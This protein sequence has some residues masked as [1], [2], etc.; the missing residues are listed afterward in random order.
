M[1]DLN[2]WAAPPAEAD[3]WVLPA[4][5]PAPTRARIGNPALAA[6]RAMQPQLG[7]LPG[8]HVA[9]PAPAPLDFERN[10]SRIERPAEVE[11]PPAPRQMT[12]GEQAY[13]EMGTLDRMGDQV[14]SGVETLRQ[15]FLTMPMMQAISRLRELDEVDAAPDF[16]T[17]AP[18]SQRLAGPEMAEERARQRAAAEARLGEVLGGILASQGRQE[19]LAANPRAR[20]LVEAGNAGRWGEVWSLLRDDPAGIIQQFSVESAPNAALSIIPGLAGAALGGRGLAFAAGGVGGYA[21]DVGPRMIEGLTQFMQSTGVDTRDPAAVRTWIGANPQLVALAAQE[22][23]RGALGPAIADALTMGLA[24]GIRPGAGVVRNTGRVTANVGMETGFEMGG[25]ALA[26]VLARGEVDKPGEILAEGLGALPQTVGSTAVGT[27][28]ELRDRTPAAPT[29]SP[30]AA[31]PGGAGTPPL[32]PSAAPQPGSSPQPGAPEGAAAPNPIPGAPVAATPISGAADAAGT[33][34][35]APPAAMPSAGAAPPGVQAPPPAQPALA[36]V[37]AAPPP[38]PPPPVNTAAASLEAALNQRDPAVVAAERAATVQRWQAALPQGFEVVEEDGVFSVLDPTGDWIAQSD[39]PTD[40]T[41]AES[42]ADIQ[43]R[44]RQGLYPEV[45]ATQQ[46]FGEPEQVA[47]AQQLAQQ[48]RERQAAERAAAEEAERAQKEQERQA[49]E[50]ERGRRQELAGLAREMRAI[51]AEFAQIGDAE[52]AK[53]IRGSIQPRLAAGDLTRDAVDRMRAYLTQ[54]KARRDAEKAAAAPGVLDSATIAGIQSGVASLDPEMREL[55]AEQMARKL[56]KKGSLDWR[57]VPQELNAAMDTVA[58]GA[59]RAGLQANPQ[60]VIALVRGG[61]NSPAT[62]QPPAPNVTTPAPAPT[63]A[64]G[65]GVGNVTTPPADVTDGEADEVANRPARTIE[66]ARRALEVAGSVLLPDGRRVGVVQTPRAGWIIRTRQADGRVRELG[67]DPRG[68][69]FSRDEAIARALRDERFPDAT[70]A[71]AATTP[72]AAP[73]TPIIEQ[74]PEPSAPASPPTGEGAP[75]QAPATAAAPQGPASA[76]PPDDLDDVFDEIADEEDAKAAVAAAPPAT[77]DPDAADDAGREAAKHAADITGHEAAHIG[78]GFALTQSVNI[79]GKLILTPVLPNGSYLRRDI[80]SVDAPPAGMAQDVFD[81]AKAAASRIRAENDAIAERMPDGPFQGDETVVGIGALGELAANYVRDFARLVGL[82]ERRFL[83]VDGSLT[84]AQARERGV[85]GNFIRGA[86]PIP[87][88]SRDLAEVGE[89]VDGKATIIRL[90]ARVRRAQ[91]PETMAHEIGHVLEKLALREAPDETKAAIRAAFE[92]FAGRTATLPFGEFAAALRA[93]VTARS[94]QR[95]AGRDGTLEIPVK[96]IGNAAYWQ[97]FSEWFA[98]QVARWAVTDEKPLTIVDRFFAR[99][100]RLYRRLVARVGGISGQPAPAVRD[101]LNARQHPPVVPTGD[102]PAAPAPSETTGKSDQPPP[103]PAAPSA[104]APTGGVKAAAAALQAIMLGQKGR[105]MSEGGTAPAADPA[106]FDADTYALVMPQLR[107]AVQEFREA[108]G[109]V[110]QL[111]RLTYT[112]LTAEVAAENRAQFREWVKPYITQFARDVTSGKVRLEEEPNDA[113]PAIQPDGAE[114]LD[115]VAPEGGGGNAEGGNTRPGGAGGQQGSRPPGGRSGGGRRPGPRSGGNR[116]PAGD[117]PAAGAGPDV[118]PEATPSEKIEASSPINVPALDF[119]IDSSLELGRGTELAKFADNMEAIRT[120]KKIEREGRRASPDE[121]RVLARYVGWGGLKNAFRVAGARE[122]EGVTKGWEKRVA[123]VEDLL[124]PAELKAARNSTTAAHY[125]SQTVVQAMWRAVERLGFKGGSVLEPSVGTGNFLGLMPEGLRGTSRVFAVEYDSLTA[126]MAQNLYPNQTVIHSGFQSVPLPSGQFALAIGNPPFGRESLFFRSRPEVNG[127]SIHNQFFLASIDAVAPGGL[128]SMVVSHNLMDALDN[129]TR[130]ALAAK[131]DFLGGI[132]LPDM[133]FRENARTEVVTDILFFRRRLWA[134]EQMAIGVVEDLQARKMP[135][136]P[137]RDYL[138]MRE[139]IQ[140]WTTSNEIPDPAGSGENIN[141]NRYFERR[142]QMVVG[143]INA[144]GTMNARRELNVTLADPSQFEPRLNAAIERLPLGRRMDDLAQTSLQQFETMADAMRLAVEGA[145]DGRITRSPDGTLKMVLSMDGGSLGRNVL[146]EITL[147]ADTP[148]NDEYTYTADGKWQRTVDV[149]G[150]DGKKAKV[151]DAE[152]RPTKRNEKQTLTFEREADIPARDRYGATRIAMVRDMLAVKDLLK[153]QLMLET[154]DAP[155]ARIEENRGRLN[156]AYDAFVAKHGQMHSPDV[157]RIA[158]RM[159]DGGLIMATEQVGGS[160]KAPTYKKAAIMSRRVTA[161][162]KPVERAKDAEDAVAIV[163]GESGFIDIDRVAQLLNTDEAGAERALAAGDNPRAFFDPELKRWEARDLYLS[164]LVRKKMLAAEAAG[165]DAN[166]KALAEVIPAD[167]DSSQITPNLGSNWIPGAIY[168]D[169]FKHLGYRDAAVSY[170]QLTNSFSVSFDGEPAAQWQVDGNAREIGAVVDRVLNSQPQTVMYTPIGG[171]TPVVDQEA[172]ESGKQKASEAF[173]EFLDWAFKDD[174]RRAEL[175]RVFNEKF[176]TRLIRQR[177]GSHLTLPGKVPDTVIKMR[178]HQM[179]AIWR[180][181][182]DPAVLYDHVVGAG[183]TFTAIARIMERRRMGLT[184]KAMVV[185]PNH[186]VE[187]WAADVTKLY[188]GAK[189]LAAGKADFERSNRRRLFARIAT[190]DFDMA[191]VGHSS[192]GFIDLSPATE[193]RYLLEELQSAMAAVREA[194][195]EAIASGYSGFGKPLGVKQ[196]ERLVTTLQQRLDRLR[197]GRRDRLLTFEEMGIDDLT[198]DEAHEFKNLSYSSRLSGVSGM[199][200]KTGSGKAMDLHL[201]VRA[202]RERKGTSV[203]FM[204]GTPISNSVA[205]MY[206]LLRNLTPNELREL[207][208]SHF[209]AWRTLFVSAATAWEPTESG[210]LKEVTRLGREW[211]NMRSLMDLYYSVADAVTLDDIKGAFAEDNPGKQFPVPAITSARRGEGDRAM[212]AVKPTPEQREIL[213]QVV[214]GF[215]GLPGISDPDERNAERLRLMDRARKISLDPRA[216]D[217]RAVV[218]SKGGKIAAVVENVARIHKKWE[219]DRGTQIIFLDRSV[220]SARG[221]DKIVAAYDDL[222]AR[223]DAAIRAGDDKAEGALLDDLAKYNP[224]E[225][226]SLR[227]AL[228]GGW[229]AYDEIKTQLIAE[230]VPADEIRFIQEANTDQQKADLFALVKEGKVRV[231]IGSTPRLGAGTNVQDRLVALHHVDVTWKPSDIEQREG[232]IVR[233]GNLLLEK[234][235]DEFEVEI[236]AYATEM[237]VDAKM[238]SLN[239]AKLKA[240][241]GIRKYDGSFQMEFDD[242]ESASMAEMAALATGNPLMVE[243]V[244]LSGEIQKLEV[245]QRS[246]SNRIN[247]LRDKARGYERDI[248]SAPQ[249][250]ADNNAFAEAVEEGIAAA[251]AESAGRSITVQGQSYA[252]EQAADE[253]AKAAIKAIRGDDT[254]VRFSIEVGGELRTSLEAVENTIR[255]AFGTPGF[256]MEIDGTAYRDLHEAAKAITAKLNAPNRGDA[257]TVGG[258]KLNGI[259]IEADVFDRWGR[260][261]VQVSALN[262]AGRTMEE[263]SESVKDTGPIL[264]ATVRAKLANVFTGIKSGESYLRNAR[265]W[266]SAARKAEDELPALREET[267]K[268]WPK[269]EELQTKR[270]RLSRVTELL[271]GAS[272][273]DLPADAPIAASPIRFRPGS[274]TTIDADG[275]MDQDDIDASAPDGW[276]EVGDLPPVDPI[277]PAALRAL[278]DVLRTIAGPE[279]VLELSRDGLAGANGTAMGPLVRLAY[280]IG[281]EMAQGV[282]LHE[283]IHILRNLGKITDAEWAILT[284]AAR[285]EGW[286]ERFNI[287][288]R[289]RARYGAEE[290][291]GSRRTAAERMEEEAVADAFRAWGTGLLPQPS[292]AVARIF[293]KI[294]QFL[295]RLRNAMQGRGF[296]DVESIFQRIERGE[297]GARAPAE[298]RRSR[299]SARQASRAMDNRFGGD[300]VIDA[301]LP[302]DRLPAWVGDREDQMA[303]RM[304]AA[305]AGDDDIMLS[306][307]DDA[308]AILAKAKPPS[309]LRDFLEKRGLA[310]V[311]GVKARVDDRNQPPAW[312]RGWRVAPILNMILPPDVVTKGTPLDA[313]RRQAQQRME[314]MDNWQQ[315]LEGEFDDARKAIEAGGGKFENV[316]AAVWM[317]DAQAIANNDADAYADLFDEMGLN[318]AEQDG[319]RRVRALYDKAGRLTDQHRRAMMVWAQRRKT[320]VSRAMGRLME[321]A[322]VD[323]PAYRKLNRRKHYLRGKM[324]E[325]KGDPAAIT[326]EIADLDARLRGLRDADEAIT[327]RMDALQEEYDALEA[328]VAETSVR[329]R[330]QSY[331]GH[332]FFGSW[333]LFRVDGQNEETG[334]EILTEINSDQG[335]FG[336]QEAALRAAKEHLA[337]NPDAEFVVR[338]KAIMFPGPDGVP[339]T[340]AA[341]GRLLAQME[342]ATEMGRADVRDLLAGVAARRGRRRSAP[343]LLRRGTDEDPAGHQGFVR[344]LDRAMRAHIAQTTRYVALDR[345]KFELVSLQ[346]REGL[347]PLKNNAGQDARIKEVTRWLDAYWRDVTGGKQPLEAALDTWLMSHPVG[348]PMG[349]AAATLLVVGPDSPVLGAGLAAYV[350]GRMGYAVA[351]GGEFP[352]RSTVDRFVSDQAQLKLGLFLNIASP[353]INLLQVA[354]TVWPHLKEKWTGEGIKRATLAMTSQIPFVREA[355][356]EDE[357]KQ[358]ERD[359]RLLERANIKTSFGFADWSPTHAKALKGFRYYSMFFFAGAEQAN[360]SVA[361]LGAYYR[362]LDRGAKAGDA[363]R[364]AIDFNAKVNF[365]GQSANR[366]ELLRLQWAR[367]PTQFWHFMF[368]YLRLALGL[369]HEDWG[370]M[371]RFFGALFVV[372]GLIGLPL[373]LGPLDWLFEHFFKTKLSTLIA[374]QASDWALALGLPAWIGQVVARGVPAAADVDI[375]GRVGMGRGFLPEQASDLAGPFF[376]TGARLQQLAA[377]D[378]ATTADYLTAVSPAFNWL[379]VLE[380]A[381]NGADATSLAFLS[382]RAFGD[383]LARWTTPYDEAQTD[384]YPTTGELIRRGLGFQPLAAAQM[385]DMRAGMAADTRTRRARENRYLS[386]IVQAVW[387][388]R[389]DRI[390]AIVAEARRNGVP[391][392]QQRVVEKVREAQRTRIE[393]QIRNQPRRE[394]GDLQRERGVI[395]DGRATP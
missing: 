4:E 394:R 157:A 291:A 101:F 19:Q 340:D 245:Q 366:S 346:E 182:T 112:A 146:R 11:E 212:V 129:S 282:L 339:L 153:Q 143:Q 53:R 305:M 206:L 179:N 176:N 23:G 67:G 113:G 296:A 3:D 55:W 165:L 311:S 374:R 15:G 105:K 286:A 64:T 333:R 266:E 18:R 31:V 244:M 130:L 258:M 272:F 381:A 25:E 330:R 163:L 69:G 139:E 359:L 280:S 226:A 204:T 13:G 26:Q 316:Q 28:A 389:Q 335:F 35:A 202:L 119:I 121:Q 235:G 2:D 233:Q 9:P 379:K 183:K 32:P 288:A 160:K 301:D 188:P 364:E 192:F 347:S 220:P 319:Y 243:R 10:R 375:S 99:L 214:E 54:E 322:G 392:T 228:A 132:R 27:I 307:P 234:Y 248:E 290:R 215:E 395:E 241:N 20:A 161:P 342:K 249:K 384:Y 357:R 367:L 349:A 207:G 283:A 24:R 353:A 295:N 289:Y 186:L 80:A 231:L 331:A 324:R 100:G 387:D 300:G 326:A 47:A 68:G 158:L 217:P 135:K 70:A 328:K 369:R 96:E 104:P 44:L 184:Q 351:K 293:Q 36:G 219:A 167:W 211:M 368:S 106:G 270:E 37:T 388:E 196:A 312:M 111:M 277:D 210:G 78:R 313:F 134:D 93:P 43:Q 385:A 200:N 51:A 117:P 252:S 325:G 308:R 115:P 246:Y 194:E 88:G 256:S 251:R 273:N 142:P 178:R 86:L 8:G 218:T 76:A 66:E 91:I 14:V 371:L 222:R 137:T 341:Y 71:A 124:T 1:D 75:N 154:D 310:P 108:W 350:G 185:V 42:V 126:R 237:T 287:E 321:S 155:P 362:A 82:T 17:L 148:F 354:Q 151:L 21:A 285:R 250:I 358:A 201:K 304:R 338:R 269:R 125:T 265:Y 152:G 197:S 123:D 34:A 127:K 208:M 239:A 315:R 279:A 195:E 89:S 120:L 336:T 278:L 7:P 172:T 94:L 84:P 61:Q 177:D 50:A 114:P 383:G 79:M 356:S 22:A 281:K 40:Q 329:E 168:A 85:V 380:A 393:R 5:P 33:G 90:N 103:P 303:A 360:R 343:F 52:Q 193:E 275:T 259:T 230:G 255:Q 16:R 171:D 72:A 164:G 372:A 118:E 355:M 122:G 318:D 391:L 390:P 131:A 260:R 175:V 181:I 83:I 227:A 190:N 294:R 95:R 376:G 373:V 213:A 174:D 317:A 141:I 232:R 267:E 302:A 261:T 205:E 225:I 169:F 147:T 297:M 323:S 309:W 156:E 74:E 292:G 216:V 268:P 361:F 199:G 334:E 38:P 39:N 98:D 274:T 48:E 254:K 363:F 263:A 173:N 299:T 150:A 116:P 377:S 203:A 149:K 370:T 221:D 327:A 242:E 162:P 12:S 109:D 276:G 45:T 6:V 145:E 352:L 271:A 365:D 102:A 59:V 247:A 65:S 236:I 238:W 314:R 345:L 110:R 128:M 133:A 191:I 57:D 240:I 262:P 170:S 138:E 332:K 320:E 166:V 136:E 253:A 209:D 344:D 62:S 87:A 198:V 92:A 107:G 348:V 58:F 187:Q 306:L 229:N 77:E 144:T 189:V 223:L 257:R 49:A 41:I 97:S 298:N 30:P 180:G 56:A 264:V 224:D 81:R 29:P 46:P 382:G 337:T 159:P 284:D 140:S 60:A 63:P 73:T 386:D 378:A